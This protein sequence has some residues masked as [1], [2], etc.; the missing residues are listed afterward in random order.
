MNNNN[1]VNDAENVVY[2]VTLENRYLTKP[3]Q[4]LL[5][6]TNMGV[7]DYRTDTTFTSADNKNN[8]YYGL[9]TG[10]IFFE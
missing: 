9:A 5:V 3:N 6:S 1:F 7:T 2:N 4:N 8:T 10:Y